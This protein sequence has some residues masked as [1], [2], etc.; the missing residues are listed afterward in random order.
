MPQTLRRTARAVAAT[1]A[2][3]TAT[4]TTVVAAP[5]ATAEAVTPTVVAAPAASTA[6]VPP[7]PGRCPTN[8]LLSFST[9][10]TAGT[11]RLGDAAVV[12]GS[13]GRA[14][15]VQV[16]NAAGRLTSRVAPANTAFAPV[17]TTVGLLSFPTTIRATSV[18]QGPAG[19]DARGLTAVL[20]GN[21]V[22]TA[23]IFGSTCE[24]PLRLRLTTGRSG[25]LTGQSFRD[26]RGVQTG[27]LV[28]GT[29]AVPAIQP[30]ATC[31]PVIAALTNVLL[32]LPL[33]A[34]RSS[35]S[36]GATLVFR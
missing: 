32:G 11:I 36:Y 20:A 22:A 25:A 19:L 5:A 26:V 8:G 10:L 1:A 2:A 28:D 3:V 33:P 34:G 23:D 21:V 4:V 13:T 6:P 14:C 24:I 9:S 35:V 12:T 17:Q 15:G 18:L 31:N 30:S 7:G 27:R 29:F 16:V